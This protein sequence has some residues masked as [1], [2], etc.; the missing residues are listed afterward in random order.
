M[1][2]YKLLLCNNNNI[3][4]LGSV[5]N[6]SWSDSTDTLGMELSFDKI[7][8]DEKYAP[9]TV[10]AVGEPIVLL[11]G[12]NEVFRGVITEEGFGSRTQKPYTAYDYAFY[13]NKSEIIIQFNSIRADLAIKQ[14]CQKVNVPVGNITSIKTIIKKIYKDQ[15]ISDVIKDILETAENELGIKYRFEMRQGKLYIEKYTDLIVTA[16]YQ[17]ANNLSS[18][19]ATQVATPSGTRS[20]S[21]MKNHVI[22]ASSGDD[23]LGIMAEAVD[24][25]GVSKYGLLQ[26]VETV[27]NINI[28]QA[29]NIANAK[30]KELNKITETFSQEMYGDDSVRSGR[31]LY[32]KDDYNNLD[33]FYLIKSCSHSFQNGI[34]MMNAELGEM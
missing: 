15:L 7:F 16:K 34:H 4:I 22:I 25:G 6:L 9:K 11:N 17:P 23:S 28:A 1:D 24:Q 31:L 27:D 3:D 13:L 26:V 20:I 12:S 10:V 5:E 21:E 14:L 8:S 30:L 19:D 18:F 33:A 29:R 2:N 32:V